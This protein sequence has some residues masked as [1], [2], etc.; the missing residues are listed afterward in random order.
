MRGDLVREVN[1]RLRALEA[2]GAPLGV[3]VTRADIDALLPPAAKPGFDAVLEATQRAEQGLAAARTDATRTLQAAD[4]EADR[5]LTGA[6]AAAA[7][8]VGEARTQVA[9]IAALETRDDPAGRAGLL[10]QL[11]RERI[12]AVLRQA[13]QVTAV[14]PQGGSRLILPGG[15]QP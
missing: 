7:E 2:V 4:R 13:G 12:A 10:D 6:R 14:D 15:P 8:R 9:A 3:E 5:I 1:R 11:Y